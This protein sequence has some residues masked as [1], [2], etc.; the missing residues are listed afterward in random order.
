M[1]APVEGKKRSRKPSLRLSDAEITEID[2]LIKIEHQRVEQE[3]QEIFRRDEE[4][5]QILLREDHTAGPWPERLER[6]STSDGDYVYVREGDKAHEVPAG[7][8]FLVEVSRRDGMIRYAWTGGLTFDLSQYW[9]KDPSWQF[10]MDRLGGVPAND[11]ACVIQQAIDDLLD[12]DIPLSRNVK[13]YIKYDR[14]ARSDPKRRKRDQERTLA[15]V[16]NG[17]VKW[18]TALL[19]DADFADAKT[20]AQ[21]YLAPRWR[22]VVQ[23][24][25]DRGRFSSG[26]ALDQWVRWALKR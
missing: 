21:A 10:V 13:Q 16:I 19:A 24:N 4:E 22:K 15:S 12:A 2:E 6:G 17:Q 8:P 26:R 5:R 25:H 1:R 9:S 18:L 14:H 3:G 23:D 20:R 11:W 7:H